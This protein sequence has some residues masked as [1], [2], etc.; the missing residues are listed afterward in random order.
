[1]RHNALYLSGPLDDWTPFASVADALR[2]Q[3]FDVASPP[4]FETGVLWPPVSSSEVQGY[5]SVAI[6]LVV[7][8]HAVVVLDRWVRSPNARLEVFVASKL[9]KPILSY[10]H[11]TPA[12]VPA[13][14]AYCDYRD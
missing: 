2:F 8:A 1:M 7:A 4:E 3:G 13:N 14:V 5:L 6:P 12:W 10:P 9:G 11:L